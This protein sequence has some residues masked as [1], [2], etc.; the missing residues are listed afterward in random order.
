MRIGAA[1]AGVLLVC[2]GVASASATVRISEDRGG[3][4]VSYLYKFAVIRAAGEQVMIDGTCAS[5]CTMILGQIPHD[6][7]CVTPRAV[8]GFHAAWE[9]GDQGRPVASRNGTRF[10][11]A[12]YPPEIRRWISRHGGLTSHLVYLRG[13]ELASMY[14]RCR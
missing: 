14:P 5:A 9:Y 13:R 2:L 3:R 1:L 4:I 8:L 10:L 11:L 6:R 12:T 7:I